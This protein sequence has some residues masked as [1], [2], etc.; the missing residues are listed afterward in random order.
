MMKIRKETLKKDLNNFCK[1]FK[2]TIA[3]EVWLKEDMNILNEAIKNKRLSKLDK[4]VLD[5][6]FLSRVDYDLYNYRTIGGYIGKTKITRLSNIFKAKTEKT[7]MKRIVKYIN[8]ILKGY[9]AKYDYSDQFTRIN[10][11]MDAADKVLGL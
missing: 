6:F 2:P 4:E 10:R 8:L 7:K 5:I 9:T 3:G 1:N 11:L